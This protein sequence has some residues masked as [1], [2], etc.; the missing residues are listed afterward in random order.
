MKC[1]HSVHAPLHGFFCYFWLLYFYVNPRF[2]F[3]LVLP[4]D[5]ASFSLRVVILLCFIKSNIHYVP[6]NTILVIYFILIYT[7]N[8]PLD[9]QQFLHPQPVPYSQPVLSQQSMTPCTHCITAFFT[10]LAHYCF[11]YTCKCNL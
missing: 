3:V 2:N 10:F 6:N 8:Y 1:C 7:F 5:C 9:A 11:T 4:S